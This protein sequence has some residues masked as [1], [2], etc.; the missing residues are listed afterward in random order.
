MVS[1][2]GIFMERH[3]FRQS[4]SRALLLGAIAPL[5][6]ALLWLGKISAG[7][8]IFPTDT[9][10]AYKGWYER[11]NAAKV[12][13]HYSLD[14]NFI[15]F[16]WKYYLATH[17]GADLAC[18]T[19][20][21]PLTLGHKGVKLPDASCFPLATSR[22]YTVLDPRRCLEKALPFFVGYDLGYLLL[23]LAV[24]LSVLAAL[25]R[26]QFSLVPMVV[27]AAASLGTFWVS[28]ELQYDQ[29]SFPVPFLYL[30]IACLVGAEKRRIPNWR[31]GL[32]AG[33][34]LL[35]LLSTS[36]Q[37]ILLC[38]F[39][40][41][42]VVISYFAARGW[43]RYRDFWLWVLFAAAIAYGIVLWLISPSIGDFLDQSRRY[44]SVTSPLYE[45]ILIPKRAIL[46]VL[47]LVMIPTANI[48]G[49]F[50]TIDPWKILGSFG[51]R[52]YVS[53]DT[54]T[55][56]SGSLY[57]LL[58]V[59]IGLFSWRN[60][61][62]WRGLW[63][64]PAL[65]FWSVSFGLAWLVCVLPTYKV[66]YFRLIQFTLGLGAPIFV[67]FALEQLFRVRPQ[68]LFASYRL[69]FVG[70]ISLWGLLWMASQVAKTSG[71]KALVLEKLG[72]GGILGFEPGFWDQRYHRFVERLSLQDHY[73]ITLLCV[74]VML[75]LALYGYL[76]WAHRPPRK[77]S[78]AIVWIIGLI[79]LQGLLI[80]DSAWHTWIWN[81]PQLV[82]T[83]WIV[84]HPY[85][86]RFG[87]E[88]LTQS[89]PDNAPTPP[90]NFLILYGYRPPSFY[91]SLNVDGRIRPP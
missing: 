11:G 66:V 35:V 83:A 82:R 36:L 48:L 89:S 85:W 13:N 5:T 23:A 68:R 28:K 57:A 10:G 19:S 77:P 50:D 60:Y 53:V 4:L 78:P 18:E 34:L 64:S 15:Y 69:L 49:S 54:L 87:L 75:L 80:G 27:G 32:F 8:S 39:G 52:E 41:A 30:A 12:T 37:G 31:Y 20:A 73:A 76:R 46:S 71:L 90:P 74:Q 3:P 47:I 17:A 16:P 70:W 86:Q 42:I 81:Q 25:W 24:W 51:G 1:K 84:Q 7:F 65:R 26:M 45:L 44:V 14:I 6:L 21:P 72:Q 62:T 88:G 63:R 58:L 79:V 38:G 33:L 40:F 2:R 55:N 59:F 9:Y 67:A 43:P 91:E 29:Y 56:Y 61:K 22:P